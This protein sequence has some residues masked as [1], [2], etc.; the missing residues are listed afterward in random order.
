MSVIEKAVS[1]AISVAIDNSHGYSQT[2]R[3]GPS[4]DCSSLVISAFEQAGLPLKAAGASYT[5]NMREP[6]L[7]NGFEDVTS[8][9]NL[10]TG[11]GLQR[12]DVL[13]NVVNHTAI[14]CGSGSLVHARSSEGTTDTRD[15]SGQEIRVQTYIN[16]PWDCCLRFTGAEPAVEAPAVSEI[17]QVKYVTV[18]M[19]VLQKGDKGTAVKIMQVILQS[20]YYNIGPDGADGDFG[21]NTERALRQFQNTHDLSADGICG[22]DTWNALLV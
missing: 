15:N 1:W 22:F 16:Y 4:Y 17:R 12:G 5:G 14:Y 8:K 2:V 20:R 18:Q 21:Q 6:F 11:E 9:V 13:L 10:H 7:R 19:P 3:W